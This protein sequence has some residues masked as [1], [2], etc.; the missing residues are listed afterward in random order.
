MLLG[1]VEVSVP[2]RGKGRGQREINGFTKLDDGV[3]VPLRGK[4]R[5]QQLVLT[6]ESGLTILTFPS[7]CGEKVGV[8]TCCSNTTVAVVGSFPSPCG[9]KVGVNALPAVVMYIRSA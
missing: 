6:F 5:G 9:E 8:N 4:G 7:P 2:L 3:S 1:S